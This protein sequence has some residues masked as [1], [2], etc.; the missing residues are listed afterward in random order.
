MLLVIVTYV[1]CFFCFTII[2]Y[3]VC[4]CVCVL[5]PCLK[6]SVRASCL[7]ITLVIVRYFHVR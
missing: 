6:Q 2:I 4:V 3:S 1:F 7:I 5:S